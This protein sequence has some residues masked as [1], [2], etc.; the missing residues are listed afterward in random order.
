MDMQITFLDHSGFL[1][2]LGGRC[3]IFDYSNNAPARG[4][5][6]LSGGVINPQL[7]RDKEVYVFV[8]HRHA[9]HYTPAIINWRKEIAN[10]HYIISSDVAVQEDVHYVQPNREYAIG[11][12]HI[13]TYKSTDEGVAF[14]V[15]VDGCAI[16][17]A[18]DLNWWH[19]QGEPKEWN[20]AMGQDYARE[21]D[22]LQ[23][24]QID[25]AFVPVDPR[26]GQDMLRGLDYLMHT[27]KVS[28]AIPMHFWN[29]ASKVAEAFSS[30]L[31]QPYA[32]R[33][34]QPM[35][36]GEKIALHF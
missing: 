23:G 25:V 30:P 6:G 3:L 1:V 32:G 24:V 21:I 18:G 31:C 35:K 12:I 29:K 33:L 26:L 17:H 19:W 4:K 36:R 9:D 10:L 14:L 27:A 28:H 2:E 5:S 8:S 15:T 22:L 13:R 11:G 20:E 7:L 16:Y 34:V